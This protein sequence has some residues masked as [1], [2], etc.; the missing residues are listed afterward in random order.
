M[1]K[2]K[3]KNQEP[4]LNVFFEFMEEVSANKNLSREKLLD[5]LK[6][7]FLVSHQ[8]KYGLHADLKVVIDSK[9]KDI[10]VLHNRKVAERSSVSNGEIGIEEARKK[11]A[12]VQLDDIIEERYEPLSFSRSMATKIRQ[13]LVQRLRELEKEVIYDEFKEKE[14]DLINGYFLRWRDREIV[15]IDIGRTEAILP[16]REQIPEERFRPGDRVKALIKTVELR[17]E[18]TREPGPYIILSRASPYFVQNTF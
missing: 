5:I 12:D 8:Y 6:E 10:Y 14:G 11:K 18:K 3:K 16:R 1:P 7:S 17:R 9:E 15:Y 13:T 2:T 4:N